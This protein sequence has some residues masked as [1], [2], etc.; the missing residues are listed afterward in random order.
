MSEV[1][2][3]THAFL[4]AI[5]DDSRLGPLSRE[6]ILA[7]ADVVLLSHVSLWEI[8]IKHSLGRSD[9]PLSAAQAIQWAEQAGFLLLPLNLPHMLMLEQ[10]PHHHRDPFDRLLIAQAISESLTLL[11]ADGAFTA[12][13]GLLQ[14]ARR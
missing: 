13:G 14:D 4:W 12:Y 6:L 7:G 9:M 2:L 1:L 5:A 11:S 10:L 8:A 3:D